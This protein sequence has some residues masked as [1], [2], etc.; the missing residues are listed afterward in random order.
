MKDVKKA[1]PVLVSA[2]IWA[3]VMIACGKIL[4]GTGAS[5]AV[6]N[7]LICGAST[8]LFLLSG[9]AVSGKKKEC[10]N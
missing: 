10:S 1:I 9:T 5:D 7:I 6:R 2:L 4:Q 8:H 3:A